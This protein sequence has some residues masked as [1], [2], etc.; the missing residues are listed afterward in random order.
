M[1]LYQHLGVGPPKLDHF[2]AN[3]Y[4]YLLKI[5]N[6]IFLWNKGIYNSFEGFGNCET[7][8]NTSVN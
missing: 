2:G 6:N 8:L 5:K 4:I 1:L 7:F 3:N